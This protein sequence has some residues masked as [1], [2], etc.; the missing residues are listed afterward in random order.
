MNCRFC[1]APLK[2]EFLDLVNAPPSNSFIESAQLND[3]E[4]YYPLK[5][6]VCDKCFLVQID[7]YKK[8][9][10]I[11]NEDYIYFSSYSS[12]WLEHASQYC[13]MIIERLSIDGNSFVVEV[14]CNDGYLLK[15]FL[16]NNIP[17]LGIEPSTKTAD[18]AS[19]KGIEVVRAFFGESLALSLR[20]K[21]QEADLLIGNNVLAHVPDINDF[22][23][24]LKKLLK[25]NGTITLEFPHLKNL[26][27]NTQFDTVYHEHFSYFSF[28]TVHKIFDAHGLDLYD[29]DELSTHGG[30]LRVYGKHKSDRSKEISHKVFDLVEIEKSA[31]MD[32]LEYYTNFQ[33]KVNLLKL[34]YWMLF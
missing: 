2:F 4:Y 28:Q 21:G 11:F 33:D 6:F 30:S 8:S 32:H 18:E 26:V 34:K 14:A 20:Q 7:E 24:G 31:R 12:S 13:E 23:L 5:L 29:V 9:K 25:K 16:D 15:N 17:C 1:K 3:P 10:A 22:V 19:R 27:E